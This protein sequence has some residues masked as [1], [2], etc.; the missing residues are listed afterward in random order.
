MDSK[1]EAIDLSQKTFNDTVDLIDSA[2]DSAYAET[3]M[4]LH[5]LQTN[6]K[7]WIHEME[8]E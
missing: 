7:N 5:L 2:D 8:N 3:T 1:H 4:I 6:H